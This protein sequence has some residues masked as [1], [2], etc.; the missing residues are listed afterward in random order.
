MITRTSDFARDVQGLLT[1]SIVSPV[2]TNE[3]FGE[4]GERSL[5]EY[6]RFHIAFKS[7]AFYYNNL[8][9]HFRI[10]DLIVFLK[11][12]ITSDSHLFRA[13]EIRAPQVPGHLISEISCT[14]TVTDNAPCEIAVSLDYNTTFPLQK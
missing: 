11:I 4:L 1:E 7:P 2:V 14:G 13:C 9:P 5:K 6:P 10:G 3:S 8:R 12:P